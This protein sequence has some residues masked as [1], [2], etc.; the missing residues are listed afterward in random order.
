M[1]ELS[2]G[3]R[4]SIISLQKAGHS[5]SEIGGILEIPTPPVSTTIRRFKATGNIQSASRRDGLVKIDKRT[6]HRVLREIEVQPNHPWK[7]YASNFDVA[8]T[9]TARAA[10][11]D[12]LHKPKARETLL[13]P[14]TCSQASG[15]GS[16]QL[17]D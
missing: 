8:P 16:E 6:Q 7:H 14:S 5:H 1:S 15:V 17:S 12:G 2:E 4:H 13:D 3:V 11:S 9:S 10:A